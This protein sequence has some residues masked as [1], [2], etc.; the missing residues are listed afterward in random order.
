MDRNAVLVANEG[1]RILM[2]NDVKTLAPYYLASNDEL[3]NAW[4]V[5]QARGYGE[6]RGNHWRITSEQLSQD[7]SV[8]R[9]EVY[10]VRQEE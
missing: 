6:R 9:L 3:W 4:C 7:V 8:M 1:M 5:I 10:F 2:K